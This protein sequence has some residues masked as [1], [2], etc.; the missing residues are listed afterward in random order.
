MIGRRAFIGS[1]SG[2]LLADPLGAYAQRGKVVRIGWLSLGSPITFATRLTAFRQALSELG[3]PAESTF[4]EQRWAEGRDELLAGLAAELVSLRVAIFVSVGTPATHAARQATETIP[5]VMIAVGDPVGTGLVA[6]LGR[7]GGNV[8]GVSNLAVDLSGKLLDLLRE[9]AP[10]AGAIAVLLDP[11][12][13]VHPVY[14]REIQRG[15]EKAGVRLQP[16]EARKPEELDHAFTVIARLN[17]G[18]LVVLPDPLYLIHRARIADL[19]ARHR[20]PAIY[21]ARDYTEAGGLISYGPYTPE[22]YRRAAAYVDKILKG[23]KPADL[24][25]EQPAKFE[26]VV[27]LKTARAIGVAIPQTVLL[28][29]TEIVQ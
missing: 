26:L 25:V 28:R 11:T 8:T 10:T 12:N 23:A 20:L 2:A 27:N 29:A 6:S 19:A 7:P 9:I 3:Y 22:L 17:P 13:P 16:V 1:L 21:P 14:W 18:G 4:I 15:A 24:P 5:I